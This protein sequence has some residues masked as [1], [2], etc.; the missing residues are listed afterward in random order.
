MITKQKDTKGLLAKKLG[1][2][3]SSLYYASKQLPKDWKLKT[4]I[5][6][7]LSGHASYGYRRI[8]DELHISRKRVQRVMQRFGMRAYRRRGRKPRKWMSSH[9]RWSAMPS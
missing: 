1:I 3:R 2:S 6:Q 9:G 8:A 7:V 5:E 4:E